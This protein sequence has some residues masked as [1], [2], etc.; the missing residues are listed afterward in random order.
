MNIS[1][2]TTSDRAE[3]TWA[4]TSLT[5]EQGR[6]EAVHARIDELAVQLSQEVIALWQARFEAVQAEN[7]T[8]H[9][10]VSSLMTE[11]MNLKAELALWRPRT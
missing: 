4:G 6:N 1:E 11:N 10:R 9:A 8:L 3:L 2:M 5:V 7:E